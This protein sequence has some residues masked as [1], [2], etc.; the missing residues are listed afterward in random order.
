MLANSLS[1]RSSKARNVSRSLIRLP[2]IARTEDSAAY[3]ASSSLRFTALGRGA[4][5]DATAWRSRPT[6]SSRMGRKD[7]TRRA[8]SSSTVQILV[9]DGGLVLEL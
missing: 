4:A 5:A 7:W 6:S 2:I 1:P 8:L 3:T 9:L